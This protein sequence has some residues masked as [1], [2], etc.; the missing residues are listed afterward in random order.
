M[1]HASTTW[2]LHPA[3]I[4][5]TIRLK[6]DPTHAIATPAR[7]RHSGSRR[8]YIDWLRGLA[9]LIMI[10]THVLDAWTRPADRGS[11]LFGYAKVLG[12]FAA[13]LFLF[14]AGVAVVFAT[15]ARLKKTG[16]LALAARSV[17]IRGWQIFGLALLFRFQAWVLNPAASIVQLLKVD[18]LNIMGPMIAFAAI[19]CGAARERGSRL[20]TFGLATALTVLATPPVRAT[21]VLAWLP[22]PVEGYLRP[23]GAYHDFTLFPWAGFVFAGAFVGTL[24]DRPRSRAEDLAFHGR[25]AGA[26]L[27][28]AVASDYAW[29]LPS[30]Y[31]R[32]EFWTTSPTF[33]FMRTGILVA[34]VGIVFLQQSLPPVSALGRL[35][36]RS[37]SERVKR[38]SHAS[39][40]GS[41]GLREGAAWG[42]GGPT[43]DRAWRGAGVPA[44]QE[45]RERA[46]GAGGA[47][48]PGSN[49]M[50]RFGRSSLLVYWV[51]VEIAY[52]VLTKRLYHHLPLER[53]ISGFVALSLLMFAMVVVKDSIKERWKGRRQR[54][55]QPAD[56]A[57]AT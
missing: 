39:G 38:A 53:S 49:M 13:P 26:G 12:G 17:Q 33:F 27:A 45:K 43:S 4:A 52:G 6:A 35:R 31:A 15:R 2:S 19:M 47:K 57:V 56:M 42:D 3:Q 28:L 24:L 50:Q 21:G 18:I 37:A 22:D 48:P 23:A 41:E 55:R 11:V 5:R 20:V 10:E 1:A 7:A 30:I 9:I 40:A 16:S 46:G 36:A 8:G 29:Y 34:A 54:Q 44:I 51:H 32:T 14:L 25:L